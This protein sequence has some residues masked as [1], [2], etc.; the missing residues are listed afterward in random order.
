MSLLFQNVN[1]SGRIQTA[2]ATKKNGALQEANSGF[3][4]EAISAL[5]ALGRNETERFPGA[6]SGRGNAETMSNLGD[7][8]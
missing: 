8:E 7:A 3:V 4:V 6:Q 5:G 1:D 2:G